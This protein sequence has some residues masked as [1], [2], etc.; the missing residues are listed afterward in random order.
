MC[1][2]PKVKK[3]NSTASDIN[4]NC[5]KMGKDRKC[6]F[7][8][9]LE[10]FT[11][12]SNEG[13]NSTQPVMDME[14][15]VS[16]GKSASICPFYYTRSLVEKAELVLLPYNYLFDKDARETTLADIPWDNAVVIFDEAHNLESFA[17]ESASFDLSTTDIAGCVREIQKAVAVIQMQPEMNPGLKLENLLKMKMIFLKL[18]SYIENLSN[19]SAYNGN[20]MI[21]LFQKGAGISHANHEIFIDEVR[22][23]NDM[24]MDLKG[25]GAVRGSQR[26]EH[27]VQC[28]RR[29]FGTALESRCLAKAAFYR[30]HVAP[31]PVGNQAT[32]I[33][34]TVSYWC[35]APSL[36]M[37]ELAN[38]NIRSILV[39]SGTLAPLPS[40]SME[41]G[42]P[43]PHTLEN[44]HIVS[45]EQIHVRVIGKGVSGKLLSSSYERRKSNEYY[46]EL[47]NTLVSIAKVTPAGMLIFFPSYS[48]M[49]RCLEEWGGP[50]AYR[51]N[52]KPGSNFF[53]ARAKKQSGS[54]KFS[55]PFAQSAFKSFQPSNAA[56]VPWKR[57][58]AT[59]S[60]V[61]EPR[62]SA[63]LPDAISEFTKYL[64]MPKSP[65][66]ILMGVCRGKISEGI[67]FANEQSRAV[68][69]TGLP[70]PP[71]HDPK[72][73]MKRDFLDESRTSANS[74]ASAN[75]G[76]GQK[77]KL[78]VQRL[79]GHD[80]YSQQAHRAVNQAI[81]RVIRNRA[82]YGAVLLLDSRFSQPSNQA[83]LSKWLR[84]HIQDDEG[85]GTAV[86]GLA[87]FYRTAESTAK[88]V[89]EE[90][91]RAAQ[92]A[93]L[94][95][96][97]DEANDPEED[98]SGK[99]ALVRTNEGA[100][101]QSDTTS[102]AY[103]APRNI[104]AR[105]NVDNLQ[106]P[107]A[108]EE[109][110]DRKP[111]P[112]P[113]SNLTH[114]PETQRSGSST[115]H[116]SSQDLSKRLAALFM[117][118]VT[119]KLSKVDQSTIRKAV[120][121][122]KEAGEKRDTKKYLSFAGSVVKLVEK[123][124]QFESQSGPAESRMLFQFF[125][126][127]PRQY[128]TV[129]ELR[130]FEL[131]YDASTL[132]KLCKD[133]LEASQFAAIRSLSTKLL[134]SLWC[135]Q[136][137]VPLS[138]EMYLRE[139]HDLFSKLKQCSKPSLATLVAAYSK[140]IPK[141]FRSVTRAWMDD[142]TARSRLS[143]ARH[144]SLPTSKELNPEKN[145]SSI[146]QAVG[147]K[148]RRIGGDSENQMNHV[149]NPYNS[150]KK[151]SMSSTTT[152]PSSVSQKAPPT[153]VSSLIQNAEAE[154]YVKETPRE[155]IQKLNVEALKDVTCPICLALCKEPF[156]ADC[157]HMACLSCW[158]GWLKKSGN[159]MTCKAPTSKERLARA[160]VYNGAAQIASTSA[161]LADNDSDD[162]LEV[163]K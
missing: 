61:V 163:C 145:N 59:K 125:G 39:T 72:V 66:C 41:L 22:K 25:N 70:F 113:A 93:I 35:F 3:Q 23:V 121:A 28:L 42:L 69:I 76:F 107:L 130:S 142:V 2:N 152:M 77:T 128:R 44:P 123:V 50:T 156:I 15:L 155:V 143:K 12:P 92:V 43:F 90:N 105:V 10:G 46:A 57:L 141:Q 79:S 1:V 83:G 5:S 137:E 63:E 34:R 114:R 88:A 111:A 24:L 147:M 101:K 119:T 19:Q 87:T 81:G 53:A 9:N 116:T 91:K 135:R 48:V 85:F 160:A 11:A 32:N 126:L 136:R 27:F 150:R 56:A 151:L 75:G 47:G 8:N 21:E 95:Y 6:R 115:S 154:V 138:K 68:V 162:E 127:L 33:G 112:T 62:S 117:E 153:S 132:G 82:D 89:A 124:E 99:V 161:L 38:L 158:L 80:W 29:V 149:S 97:D 26:L 110:A 64:G 40:Y 103:V 16:M 140:L 131:V 37:E 84:P 65:G 106:R 104:V 144:P 148:K 30:V 51:K 129:V 108:N 55:F 54:K 67:D 159:C 102:S 20:F 100:D 133:N 98:F 86:R 122:M 71:S 17:S 52:A 139:T 118:N 45:D 157:G 146:L 96:D 134:Q 4:H 120:V 49:E 14:E 73:K 60:I 74:M 109:K 94:E 36:A 18:E 58:L 31:K 78:A 7:R 13:C